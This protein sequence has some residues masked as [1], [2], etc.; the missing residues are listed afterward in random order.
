MWF[1][2]KISFAGFAGIAGFAEAAFPAFGG[3]PLGNG[4]SLVLYRFFA[5]DRES[6]RLRIASAACSG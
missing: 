1:I 4:V 6:A 5:P 2:L 3:H